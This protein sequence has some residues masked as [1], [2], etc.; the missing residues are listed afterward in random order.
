MPS[1]FRIS[2]QGRPP[3]LGKHG[4]LLTWLLPLCS[5]RLLRSRL[6]LGFLTLSYSPVIADSPCCNPE[7]ALLGNPFGVCVTTLDVH[8][9]LLL[10]CWICHLFCTLPGG[11]TILL[12]SPVWS[13]QAL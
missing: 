2:S 3:L 13:L 10:P 7:S 11:Y 4:L 5:I 6:S 9:L 8:S 12:S 1:L